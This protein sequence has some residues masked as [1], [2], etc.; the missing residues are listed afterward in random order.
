MVDQHGRQRRPLDAVRVLGQQHLMMD[1]LGERG[2]GR[3]EHRQPRALAKREPVHESLQPGPAPLGA[4]HVR[5][6]D[7]GGQGAPEARGEVGRDALGGG[8]VH[9]G[10]RLGGRADE[11]A[12]QR[13]LGRR[14]RVVPVQGDHAQQRVEAAVVARGGRGGARTRSHGRGQPVGSGDAGL[15]EPVAEGFQRHA[16]PPGL[17]QDAA[18]AVGRGQGGHAGDDARRGEGVERVGGPLHLGGRAVE[19]RHADG[20]RRA[21]LAH[22]LGERVRVDLPDAVAVGPVGRR[23]LRVEVG[24]EQEAERAAALAR[25][26]PRR[27]CLGRRA[28]R[29]GGDREAD[30]RRLGHGRG[31]GAAPTWRSRLSL[32]TGNLCPPGHGLRRGR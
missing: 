7:D 22:P 26:R 8:A 24:D 16:T 9:V 27:R 31:N 28:V 13:V 19:A 30:G 20:Q 18:R 5:V 3:G 12:Q 21:V 11:G 10:G 4:A 1:G 29:V 25:G 2:P 15:G 14:R 32:Y 23:S 6:L 17:V